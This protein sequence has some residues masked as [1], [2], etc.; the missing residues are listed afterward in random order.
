M[1]WL[2]GAF[3][4]KFAEVKRLDEWGNYD[5]GGKFSNS[6]AIDAYADDYKLKIIQN[7]TRY[8]YINLIQISF[9]L[10]NSQLRNIHT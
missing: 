2:D 4:R 7:W 9:Y 3:L 1:A 8:V 5:V 6:S 10:F